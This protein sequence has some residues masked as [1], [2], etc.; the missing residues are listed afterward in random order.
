MLLQTFAA[1]PFLSLARMYHLAADDLQVGKR[2][3]EGGLGAANH[4]EV[5]SL[6][7][8]TPPETGAST[9]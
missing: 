5:L 2:L 4:H 3:F 9:M 1:W 8:A 7:P 6:R